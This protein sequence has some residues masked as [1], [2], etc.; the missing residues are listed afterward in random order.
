[1]SGFRNL[2]AAHENHSDERDASDSDVRRQVPDG[3]WLC[4]GVPCA[5][6]TQVQSSMTTARFISTLY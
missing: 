1:V 3:I 2:D 4:N 5:A 6:N